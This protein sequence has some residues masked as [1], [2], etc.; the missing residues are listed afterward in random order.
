METPIE[1]P[2]QS[3]RLLVPQFC[4]SSLFHFASFPLNHTPGLS[5]KISFGLIFLFPVSRFKHMLSDVPAP[6]LS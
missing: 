1:P 2:S 5:F 3:D 6:L 4:G